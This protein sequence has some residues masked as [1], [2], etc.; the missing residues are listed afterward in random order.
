MRTS[1]LRRISRAAA[2]TTRPATKSAAI[3]SPSGKPARAATR[4]PITASVERRSEPKWTAFDRSA[5]LPC[6]CAVRYETTVRERSITTT[7]ASAA[8]AHH[9]GSTSTSTQPA[10]RATASAPTP[11]ETSTRNPA[12]AS[13]AR[14]SAFPWP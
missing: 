10:I 3:E 13:A 12:S 5:A 9:A 7:S 1:T 4:P 2:M 6:R 11:I 14:C 8:N